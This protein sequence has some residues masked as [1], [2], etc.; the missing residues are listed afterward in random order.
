MDYIVDWLLTRRQWLRPASATGV[1]ANPTT[2]QCERHFLLLVSTLVLVHGF[3]EGNLPTARQ[4]P[5]QCEM[6]W[7]IE[8][9]VEIR[10]GKQCCV[11]GSERREGIPQN[12]SYNLPVRSY[13]SQTTSCAGEPATCSMVYAAEAQ[14]HAESISFVMQWW[15]SKFRMISLTIGWSWN[16]RFRKLTLRCIERASSA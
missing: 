16:D 12:R 3:K 15:A 6:G 5:I 7:Q 9:D 13:R 1:H 8:L 10:P 2:P 4:D 11:C 14:R